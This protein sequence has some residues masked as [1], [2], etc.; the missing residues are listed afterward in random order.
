MLT[1]KAKVVTIITVFEAQDHVADAFV[2]LGVARYSSLHVDGLGVHGRRRDGLSENKNL[3][4]VILASE[5][6][7]GRVLVWVDRD[8][9]PHFPAV[10][11]STDAVAATAG[12]LL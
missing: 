1:E 6:L 9:L 11:Y 7:A 10:A 12:P 2:Q 5:S 4:Y 3:E 8:L